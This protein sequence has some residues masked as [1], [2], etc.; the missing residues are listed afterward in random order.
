M[1][2]N[3]IFKHAPLSSFTLS[4]SG[5]VLMTYPL[6]AAYD[7]TDLHYYNMVFIQKPSAGSFFISHY[8]RRD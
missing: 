2:C 5:Q 6:G 8:F 4:E 1:V 7:M 3:G